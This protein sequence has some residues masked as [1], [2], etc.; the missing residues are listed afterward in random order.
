MSSLWKGG[1]DMKLVLSGKK[2]L[3]IT[4]LALG[5]MTFLQL[6]FISLL[7]FVTT[8]TILT[9][10]QASAFLKELNVIPMAYDKIPLYAAVCFVLLLVVMKL[11]GRLKE[12]TKNILILLVLEIILCMTMMWATFFA[13]NT[14]L[15]FVIANMMSITRKKGNK[16]L[17]LIIMMFLFLVTNYDVIRNV[18][19]ITNFQIYLSMYNADARALFLGIHNVLSTICIICFMIYMLFFVQD[20]YNESKKIQRLNLELQGLNE[21][22]KEYAQVREKMGE[23]RERNRLAREIHDTLGHTLT[24]L[25][26]G[27]E[28]CKALM[29]T[30]PNLALKQLDLLSHVAK[31]GLKDVRRS[32]S[33]LR[34]DALENH[35]LKEALE[36]MIDDFVKTTQVKVHFVCHLEKLEF[37]QDEEDTIYRIIQEG[38]TNA[39]RHGKAD[40]IYISFGK[41]KDTLIIIIEDNGIGCKQPKEGFGLHHMKERVALLN[42]NVRWYGTNGFVLIV[43]LPLREENQI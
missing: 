3:Q 23:T 2:R 43:E 5:F 33:K 38:T 40:E 32:V 30:N 24:G 15:L 12:T 34:P 11:R 7:I 8:Q 17:S 35:T 1:S 4:F 18:M 27:L 42:G 26:T 9:A 39:L 6:S 20:Q 19:P 13:S 29:N 41:E 16:G 14:I 10:H 31:D 37:Q 36:A 28:A 22:L 25:S 21:Q